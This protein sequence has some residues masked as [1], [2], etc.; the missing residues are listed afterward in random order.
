M[1][2][3]IDTDKKTLTDKAVLLIKDLNLTS[4]EVI[5]AAISFLFSSFV[6]I[7]FAQFD[8]K[9]FVGHIIILFLILLLFV[10]YS[11]RRITRKRRSESEVILLSLLISI[12]YLCASF[13]HDVSLA[14]GFLPISMILPTALVTML[15]A[16]SVDS[17]TAQVMAL[18]LPLGAFFINYFDYSALLTAISA[19]V[20]GSLVLRRARRRMDL[21]NA[22]IVVAV[23]NVIAVTAMLLINGCP[24]AKYPSILFWSLLN[25]IISGML[26]L[27]VL[28]ILEN[29]LHLA[30]TFKLIE[31]LDIGSPILQRLSTSAP[32]TWSHSMM[33]AT[34]AEEACREIGAKALLARVGAYYHD[35]GKIDQPD[36]FVE[37]QKLYN[38]HNELNPRL[39]ATVIR[40]HVK[41]G[42]EKARAIGLPTDVIDII[43]EHH[44]DSLI[45]WF[46]NAA[47][48]K[49]GEVNREDFCYPGEPP[50]TKE[51]AAVMLADVTEAA[52][53]TL[54]KPTVAR[55]EK[56]IQDLFD[57]K[58]EHGQLARSA[59]TFHDLET[60][61]NTFVR[62]LVGHY[63]SRIE[64]PK[65]E[66]ESH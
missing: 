13:A 17:R 6:S 38:K 30:T 31:L 34:L 5:V 11:G 36:Y 50:R 2:K 48:E 56:F 1:K 59:L 22:G 54:E 12:Y 28:P 37:N 45:K 57:D 32:G 49:E 62:V 15:I 33:V 46:Y 40:S 43:A 9:K 65:M 18:S 51:S 26:V 39:S 20:A 4:K 52:T 66:N 29:A 16:I 63:H 8:S 58:V 19:G 42:V 21:V 64:Y 3:I 47:K 61:K 53:R 55:L 10:F 60:I 14:D 44:G 27:G 23:T 25:G 7:S 24:F 35:I 41:L